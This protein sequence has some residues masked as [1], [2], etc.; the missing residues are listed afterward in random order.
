[1]QMTPSFFRVVHPYLPM[2][3]SILGLRQAMAGKNSGAITSSIGILV[4]F[5][6]IAIAITSIVARMKRTVTMF[7]LHP[8]ITL[9]A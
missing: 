9:E 3:Y 2:T 6:V 1:M 5:G 4:L 7:D 8:V